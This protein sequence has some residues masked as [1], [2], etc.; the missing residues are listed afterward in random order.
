MLKKIAFFKIFNEND[1]TSSRF[2]MTSILNIKK[3]Y[4][5]L[6][7]ICRFYLYPSSVS[8]TAS[9]IMSLSIIFKFLVLPIIRLESQILLII[10]GTPFEALAIASRAVSSKILVGL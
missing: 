2:M 5:H 8:L 6:I 1:V 4:K 3:I 9:I 7:D 10:L